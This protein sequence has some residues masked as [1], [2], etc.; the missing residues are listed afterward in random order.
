MTIPEAAKSIGEASSTRVRKT[1]S[2]A[3]L[4][5]DA[6]LLAEAGGER[7]HDPIGG[8]EDDGGEGDGADH[9]PVEH[10]AGQPPGGAL[11]ALA[12][13]ASV[14]GDEGGGESGA[15]KQLEDD[16]GQAH[17]HPEGVELDRSAVLVGDDDGACCAEQPAAEEGEREQQRRAEDA[18]ARAEEAAAQSGACGLVRRGAHPAPVIKF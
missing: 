11:A 14:D 13:H 2:R 7:G 12:E 15:G 16:V 5:L 17:R 9:D 10:D 1:A 3:G 4:L 6:A 8:E 18:V